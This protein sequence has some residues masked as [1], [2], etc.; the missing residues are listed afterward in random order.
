MVW[1]GSST[2]VGVLCIHCMSSVFSFSPGGGYGT[3]DISQ[4]GTWLIPQF[5]GAQLR[6]FFFLHYHSCCVFQVKEWG[7]RGSTE[8]PTWFKR[9]PWFKAVFLGDTNGSIL[10]VPVGGF[11]QRRIRSTDPQYVALLYQCSGRRRK[12]WF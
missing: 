10:V 12:R 3:L 6:V 8:L 2:L 7:I 1:N 9:F 4:V 5:H 11:R